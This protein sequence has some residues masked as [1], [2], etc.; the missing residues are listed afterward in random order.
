MRPGFRLAGGHRLDSKAYN[1][2]IEEPKNQIR[3][4]SLSSLVCKFSYIYIR[5]K[6]VTQ[7]ATFAFSLFNCQCAI[8]VILLGI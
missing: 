4:E 5:A 3:R 6:V 2:K 8:I 7:V 1:R